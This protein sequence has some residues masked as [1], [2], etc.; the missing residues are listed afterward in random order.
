MC[1]N[2]VF[3]ACSSPDDLCSDFQVSIFCTTVGRKAYRFRYLTNPATS[4]YETLLGFL[5]YEYLLPR[6]G[7]LGE[8][9]LINVSVY[10]GLSEMFNPQA[11]TRIRVQ[12]QDVLIITVDPPAPSPTFSVYED[13]RPGRTCNLYTLQIERLDGTVPAPEEVIF[14]ITGGNIGDAFGINEEGTIF[15]NNEVDR[16]T[17][18]RYE[19]IV[20]A[21]IRGADEDT[22]AKAT[23][24][25]DV[26][27]VNDNYPITADSYSVNV[28]EGM[29]N[30]Q[31]VQVIA[32]DADEGSNAE[33]TY[34][35]LGIGSE[36]FEV[37]TNGVV[38]TRPGIALN[39][40]IEDYYLLVMIITDRGEIFLSTHTVINVYV[41]TPPPSDLAF[42]EIT[43]PVVREDT[44]IGSGVLN[45]SAFEVGGDG[46]T[47][48]IRY[49][50]ID[51]T[52]IATGMSEIPPPF[53]VDEET[54]VISVNAALDAER[55]QQYLAN[56]EAYS[57]RTLFP[58]RSAFA[59]ITF[60]ITDRNELP[61]MFV[62]APYS[63]N[64][65]ENTPSGTSVSALRA[66]DNDAMNLGLT[67]SLGTPAP[68]GL[69]F[70]VSSN[71]D[72]FVSDAIDYERNATFDFTVVVRDNPTDSMPSLSATAQV[73]VNV[74][75]R[76]DNAPQFVGTPYNV[77]LRETEP[78][79]YTVLQFDTVDADS[80]VNSQVSFSAEGI[81][82]TPFCLVDRSIQVCNADLLTG[83]ENETV[84]LLELV[85]T[86]PPGLGSTVEQV[87]R[88]QVEIELI[89]INE[90]APQ[91][92][93]DNIIHSGYIEEHC[94]R[95]IGMNCSGIQVYDFGAT[96]NDMD[97]GDGG[98]L[99]FTLLTPGVPFRLTSDS[100]ILTITGRI[101][102]E[103]NELYTLMVLVSDMGDIFG[104][105][106]SSLANITIPILDIDD[107][108]PVFVEPFEFNVTES[109]TMNEFIFGRIMIEDPDIDNRHIFNVFSFLDPPISQ[110]CLVTSLSDSSPE[111]LPIQLDEITGH[112]YFC[113]PVD[114]DESGRTRFEF[115]VGVTDRNYVVDPT[116]NLVTR[117]FVV[118]VVDINDNP[119]NFEV[120]TYNF[121][122]EENLP[123]RSQVGTVRATDVD[124][125][126]NALLTFSVINGSSAVECNDEV[127]F[128]IEKAIVR[129]CQPLDY[130]IT[131]SYAFTVRVCDGAAVALCDDASVVVTVLDRNDNPP[132]FIPD[133]QYSVQ[134]NETDSSDMMSSVVTIQIMDADSPPNS[135]SD[136][137]IL[138]PSTP[139]AL[140]A[141]TE[142]SAVVYVEDADAIDFESGTI[143]YVIQV[144]ANNTPA[145]AGDEVQSA[146]ATVTIMV[147]DVNDNAPIIMSPFE[148]EVRENQPRGT[149]IG[150]VAANDADSGARGDLDYFLG[151]ADA[152][153][154][155]SP[156]D[157]F[158]INSTSGCVA[159]CDPLDFENQV[160]HSILVVVCDSISP[161]MC[162]NMTFTINVIDLNDNAPIYTE[163]PFIVNINEG[164]AINTLVAT[165]SSRDDD[166]PANSEV[167]Y[168]F[169]NTSGP[170]DINPLS[171]EV[172]YNGVEDLDFEG[173][174]RTYIVHVRGTNAP[175][176]SDDETQRS[177]VA[178]VINVVDRNDEPPIFASPSD[179][180]SI[181][182]HSPISTV[183]YSLAT[184]DGDS[185]PNAAV[186][187]EISDVGVPFAIQGT[188]VVV[189]DSSVIDYD[190]PASVRNYVLNIRAIN[191]PSA[192]DDVVQISTFTLT[193]DIT[194]INDNAPVCVGRD[195]FIITE[196]AEVSVSLVRVAANDIDDGFNGNDG[197]Q[198]FIRGNDADADSEFGSGFGS[199]LGSGDPLCNEALPFRIDP[200]NGYISICVPLDYETRITYDVNI[201]ACDMGFPRLCT[202]CPIMIIVMDEND[203]NPVIHPPLE[204][205]VSEQEPVGFEIG[206]INATDADSGQNAKI[207]FSLSLECSSDHP[208]VINDT[209]G[210]IMTCASLDFEVAVD[211]IFDIIATDNGSPNLYGSDVVTVYVIN[212]NDHAPI[213]TSP[214]FVQVEE[215]AVNELVTVVTAVDIDAPPFN[216]FTFEL[217]ND[218]GGSFVIDPQSGE[219]R[220]AI[221]L[222]REEQSMYTIE[223]RVFDGLNE[224]RETIMVE[225]I[226]I[227]DNQP[228]YLGEPTYSF[229][230]NMMF[231]LVLVF[232]DNDTGNN[233]LLSYEVS[234]SRFS[235][236][237]FG[238]LRSP[239]SLDRDPLTG[240]TPTI[241]LLVTAM[242]NG[243]PSLDTS[244][245]IT[246]V[247]L[248]VNDNAPE[249]LGP[250]TEDV[251]DGDPSGLKVLMVAA[252]DADA[253]VNAE[254][255]F[256]IN[257]PSNTFEI[258]STTGVVSLIRTV[259]L[260]SAEAQQIR[261][262]VSISDS[263]MPSQSITQEYIV[264]I[265]SSVP[266]FVEDMYSFTVN[267]NSFNVTIGDVVAE[268][269]DLN[270]D[271]DVF[272]FAIESVSPY[273]AGFS[274]ISNFTNGVLLSPPSYFDFE[275]AT[276]FNITVTV[277]QINMTEVVDHR[278][279]VIVNLVDL[280]D[281][282][283]RL[284]PL[285][286][287]AELREDARNGY[288][289]A[290]AVAIDFDTGLSGQLT[291]IHSGFGAGYFTFDGDGNFLVS[292]DG[293]IDFESN[294]TFTFVYQACDGGEPRL[295]S[296][297]GYI[298]IEVINV[299]DLPPVFNPD[300]Y[301]ML[302]SESYPANTVVLYVNFSDPDT[303]L[304]DI[305][306]QL[307]PPQEHFEVVLLFG[308]GAIMTTDVP[309]DRET[310]GTHT[311]SVIATDTA[312]S[313]DSANVSIVL[314]D[315]N[316]ERPFVDADNVVVHF[317]EGGLPVSPAAGLNIVDDDDIS[318]Y[319][320]TTLTASLLSSPTSLQR[321]PN[322]GG[323]CD[324]AN[325]SL[326]YDNNV[327]NLCGLNGCIYLLK[328][329]EVVIPPQ[330]Q[331]S[332][333][334]GILQL[335]RAQ[336]IARNPNVLLNGDQFENFT[337]TIWVRFTAPDSG[338][339][340]EVQSGSVNVF[341]VSVGVDGS[342]QVVVNPTP[343][344]SETLL[345]TGPLSTHDGQ[346]HQLALRRES[347]TLTMFFDCGMAQ[348]AVIPDSIDTAFTRAEFTAA[349]FFLGNR[350]ANG[351]YAEFY[352]CSSVA[353]QTHICCTLSC[354]ETLD[355]ASPTTDIKVSL[356]Y[357]TRA[358]ELE[359][360][361]SVNIA[362]LALLQEAMRKITY[363]NILDEPNP[364]DRGLSFSVY[365]TVGQSDVQSVV[366][367]R[368]VLVNDQR[369][370]IDLN[371]LDQAGIN[372]ETRFD[373][374]S[375]GASIIGADAILYDTDSGYW[376]IDRVIVE[377]LGNVQSLET[378]MVLPG[379]TPLNF[380]V[381]PAGNRIEI[382]SDDAQVEYFPS[383][384]INALSLI[385]Y[386]DRTEEPQEFTRQISFTVLDQGATFVND[387]LSVTTVT[388]TPSNDM[389]VLDLSVGNSNSLNT[390]AAY[391]ERRGRVLLLENA[392]LDI[393]DPD[394]THASRATFAFTRNGRPNGEREELQVD[395]S[396]LPPT[397]VSSLAYSFDSASGVLTL[398]GNYDFDTWLIILRAVEYRNNEPNPSEIDRREV[399]VTVHDD[400]G[401]ESSPAFIQ[402]TLTPFNNP[403]Q[404]FVGGP[405]MMD[406]STTFTEDGD[407]IP[408][409]SP[410][411]TLI[412]SDSTGL[413]LLRLSIS[414]IP[415]NSAGSES[416]TVVPSI[417]GAFPLGPNG[418]FFFLQPDTLDN[419]VS[420]LHQVFYCNTADEP[421]E[422]SIRQVT[423]LATDNGLTTAGGT[424]LNPSM[425][426]ISRTNIQIIR[427]N[428][429]PELSFEPLNNV[430]IRGV[431]TPIIDPDT[432]VVEDS[433][434]VFFSRL[435]I[436]IT[437]PQ[438][439]PTNEIIE[440]ARQL[441]E[442]T[443]SFGPSASPGG[444]ILY[445]VTFRD[446]GGDISRV[447]EA[448]SN[449]RYNNRATSIT[450]DP[451]RVICLTI[452]DFD[453]TSERACVMVTISP[454]NN[455]DP[456]FAPASSSITF[457]ETNNSISVANLRATDDDPGL[458]GTIS[459]D[460]SEV[461][462]FY[463]GGADDNTNNGIFV[464]DSQRGDITA[465]NGLDADA[466]TY[467]QLRVVAADMGNPVRSAELQ[468]RVDVDDINDIAPTFRGTPYI[469]IPQREELAPPRFVYL[470]TA[471]DGDASTQNSGILRYGLENYQDLFSIDSSGSILSVATLDAEIQQ[472]FLLNVSAVDTGSPPLTGYTTVQ[473]DLI[474]FNDNPALVNQLAPAIHVIDGPP[475]SIG[476][477]IRIEDEDL[478]LPAINQLEIVLTPNAADSGRT[479]DQCLVQCQETRIREA[480]LLPPAIDLLALASFQQDQADPSGE[481]NFRQ[482]QVGAGSCTAWEL[483][484]GTTLS[485]GTDDGY[486][487][488]PRG[489][490]PAD[491]A[492]GD[493]TLSV[494]LA[495]TREGYIIV[496]P[497]Q[498]N[499]DLDSGSVERTFAIWL[500][501]RDIRFYYTFNGNTGGDPAV[502]SVSQIPSIGEFF[503]PASP[504]AQTRHF[505]FIVKSS[506]PSVEL[507][508]DCESIGEVQ[509]NGVVQ[510]P[511]PNIDVFIG[512]SRPNPTN[513]GRLEGV[514]SNFFYHPTA[515]TPAQLLNFCSC[516]FEAIRLP[517]LPTSIS[518]MV[519]GDT[520]IVLNPTSNL[521]PFDDALSVLRSITYE[522]TFPSPTLDPNRELR[523]LVSEETG[524][525]ASSLGSI[526][527]V[528]AD[529]SLPVLDLTGPALAGIDYDTTFIEDADPTL[530]GPNVRIS[531]DIEDS[532]TPTFGMVIVELINPVDQTE[533]LTA[534]STSSFIEVSVSSNSRTVTITGPGIEPD[535]VSVLQTVAYV[536][537]NNNPTVNP[538]RVISFTVIDTEGRVNNPLAN[539]R[540][541]LTAVNDPPQV[542]M[543]SVPGDVVD[544]VQ[545]E[546]G[547][548]GVLLARN[549]LVMDVDNTELFSARVQLQSPNLPADALVFNN[550][551]IPAIVGSYDSTS[552][553]LDLVG[554]ASLADYETVLSSVTFT[555]TDSPLLDSNGNPVFDA[556]RT[557]TFTVSDGSLDSE[558]AQ[559]TI[560]FMP[561]NDP[562]T[563]IIN[564]TVV[565]FRDGDFSIPIAPNIEI[566]DVDTQNLFSLT[567][568][569]QGS[570]QQDL[571]SDGARDGR[572]LFYSENTTEGFTNILRRI[573]YVNFEAEPLLINRII[574]IEVCDSSSSCT[575]AT[576]VVEV[577]DTNDNPPVFS[578]NEYVFSVTENV[579]VGF[580][581]N[582]LQVTDAD[583]MAADPTFSVDSNS[584]IPFGLRSD[585]FRVHIVTTELLNFEAVDAYSFVITASD[586]VSQAVVNVMINIQNVNEQPEIVLDP[587]APSIIVGPG[588]ESQLILVNVLISDPDFDDNVDTARLSL[589]NV[590]EGS[591]ETLGWNEIMGYTFTEI[592]ENEF[593][594]TR[595]SS[596]ISLAQ[597]LQSINYI[598]GLVVADLTEIRRV[599]VT[600]LDQNGLSSEESFVTVSLA[601]IP[602]FTLDVYRINLLEGEAHQDFLQ[603]GAGVE[604]GGDVI[605]YAVDTGMGVTIDSATGFLSLVRPLDYEVERVFTFSVYAIDALP[606]ARTGTATVNVTV[607]DI[608][609]AR[610]IIGGVNNLTITS[611]VAVNL[612]PAVTVA[613]PDTV[614]QITTTNVTVIGMNSLTRSPFSGRLCVDEYNVITK[615]REVCGL[616]AGSF[617]DLLGSIASQENAILLTDAFSNNVLTN[618]EDAGYS[619]VSADFSTFEGLI[620]EFTFTVWLAP[621]TSGY[622]AY[623]GTPDST[624]RYF[625][626]YYDNSDDQ[627]IVTLKRAG[628][629][630]LSAQVR[631]IFQLQTSLS[632][633][634]YHFVMIQY[635]SRN[636]I[637]AVDGTLVRSMAVVYKEQ[638]FI[639][640]VYGKIISVMNSL[641]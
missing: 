315:E 166:S 88:E 588:S 140:R 74:L 631:V 576:I 284:S 289:V 359:Y 122:L 206:C 149:E 104:S 119:P 333:V 274:I 197:L 492:N 81:E 559:V 615:M 242:D 238:I 542:S 490:L 403:P 475:S 191:E 638:P 582:T 508:I 190:P 133:D 540:V 337:V 357:R 451:P 82:G 201:T 378:L 489:D 572:I 263:G 36:L 100:G 155:C 291:Y 598:T 373:E 637:C 78:D 416:L 594:L 466:Y 261:F 270:T 3:D 488:I 456:V 205:N 526:K 161:R 193:I 607:V 349:S 44:A 218:A 448:I 241:D 547:S 414:G 47:R 134:I 256:N 543:A 49:R 62:G 247:L 253:G 411:L 433:D 251:V 583:S 224:N 131:T 483:S 575:S 528:A 361:G 453:L 126:L 123:G 560:Q 188:T 485:S 5:G 506:P 352:F 545:F 429:R 210:C 86:N 118:N 266:M 325:Y 611:E 541:M 460:I 248:D 604:N 536:N 605:T 334:D 641:G 168:S 311:F 571:L 50:F 404:I 7:D 524:I 177:D 158:T 156:G 341:Q 521:I 292:V 298:F 42:N 272:Y 150:C 60:T 1:D 487:R 217:T 186:R 608:N 280:N 211:Y 67:Y 77:S 577:L 136:F 141:I 61:P 533:T 43:D 85:A 240:G 184:T 482:T 148:F 539:T 173:P 68:V 235:I 183:V 554:R 239:D 365:D 255:V 415:D 410:N 219:V 412:D 507:Y 449:V 591:V 563:I 450:V 400:G 14:N 70:T 307:D 230:E 56:I 112:L 355:V 458:E 354:G 171:G 566:T 499:P 441:P 257:D 204:F 531:R 510:S 29:P 426:E 393:T 27:D 610:P 233:S 39:R 423:F 308:V 360:T 16:E 632:D 243:D 30:V 163:D 618:T 332:I 8:I 388:I 144:L 606:P 160:S 493:F 245:T 41:I 302:I 97:G 297:P 590:P 613:D 342:L 461:I 75:D 102:R 370:V 556:T 329:D 457:T 120:D 79:G 421:D 222:D 312:G 397:A 622:V 13:E 601:S 90:H 15:L 180:V 249:A 452:T 518:A 621:S 83:I 321:Y 600:V 63:I 322:P 546:E 199:A 237:A 418:V 479:Y 578:Q 550:M 376:P 392:A 327:H 494:V 203:N 138:T 477:A 580:T 471:V 145:D 340:F 319:P 548:N 192:Q 12:N 473:L 316:D 246:I 549:V 96:T 501:R 22:T 153:S 565:Q 364:L 273:D 55:S 581:V 432:I 174:T 250:F 516:G 401:V 371:G 301:T 10:D 595:D 34:L 569:L 45:V 523:F 347:S 328:E 602:Q 567:V 362:S 366:I 159:T 285:N 551:T 196:F 596:N 32:T 264:Y 344:T 617:V 128:Y 178:L 182:E 21:R 525:E 420:A 381:T 125:G 614:G 427:M 18:S 603:V 544:T 19:L 345:N 167:Q 326:L 444:E 515:I 91:L 338:N 24:I 194:D 589:R 200:D 437:N 124:S 57:T 286:I 296:D 310:L 115:I 52:S 635:D 424:T 496:A 151:S 48:F 574:N 627:L 23:L 20:S 377:L 498:T 164:S 394:S 379:S 309:L 76:N 375:A 486:G 385:R 636:L 11:L 258:N 505:T 121:D 129:T 225:V 634:N 231:E 442:N 346:W 436:Y 37:D 440:F 108:L 287:T 53:A 462:S 215:E 87:S 454:P 387:P 111:Y 65:A 351:M 313:S 639:G 165:I 592:S 624:E 399:A 185:L 293:A 93:N 132:E 579:P 386:I 220:T 51:I 198:F 139:F 478:N 92:L 407:C 281:N 529:D 555:S 570:Q 269:R 520:R 304:T 537:T 226:D 265:V 519:E 616:P 295:C 95:G 236:D 481:P 179:E 69:P 162:S 422:T 103:E 317:N 323:A 538:P 353:T 176:F 587:P 446:I 625:T 109:M 374:T 504:T 294:M 431:P 586:G 585:G 117:T 4:R 175:F 143:T 320:L 137:S 564:S 107:N 299:D 599:S 395:P 113:R 195:A 434:N 221:A 142:N 181:P 154:D 511:S 443:D 343:T 484:R 406:Y 208:F 232:R 409:V 244:V 170:F 628:L 54:G 314:L 26:I 584:V 279:Y 430:S 339:I 130:E 259:S 278:A 172:T 517:A 114:F 447:T 502:F 214:I 71:G 28:S 469:A 350:L 464:I 300:T 212:E 9:R 110:G 527:L 213:F 17:I 532:V 216:S 228:E 640:E 330:L 89:L 509:L 398:D 629:S 612:F 227:N 372:F 382:F 491:F 363:T 445:E 306:L 275:D 573:N 630:G 558:M 623:Y 389:P 626:L 283:P 336:D 455:F 229:M 425:S 408:I 6:G 465:P 33:L 59:N 189:T 157:L 597:A 127:P 428:D 268:D 562:P 277:G 35:L 25:A 331:G 38:R 439:G 2:S 335:P 288:V 472:Q 553:T 620:T 480:N 380:S 271:N 31:V 367:L 535:F 73:T 405:N 593:S 468:L 135:A 276:Y 459:F 474:D 609:D 64:V 152:I 384:F 146:T 358:V 522:N 106:R 356:D 282:V 58:P 368:P 552:G 290:T 252:R 568:E 84:F 223:V 396:R 467:H 435:S 348:Q 503:D 463:A 105:V 262:N 495:P 476:P 116:D 419:Y 324:H 66:V 147:I 497:D 500:R 303:P 391:E 413:Q 557:V 80:P 402:I 633:G 40:T 94:G 383:E 98:I 390:T 417:E 267:E 72:I 369:P 260:T 305:T 534:V 438:D 209:S 561:V 619:V 514:I 318:L 513:G 254:L 512:Q 169:Q 530:V 101:D 46:D 202:I 99:I 207:N 470:V 187:Y 234:D